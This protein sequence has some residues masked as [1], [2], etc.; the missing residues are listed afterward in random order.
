MGGAQA[1]G[2]KKKKKSLG[3]NVIPVTSYLRFLKQFPTMLLHISN[4]NNNIN[5]AVFKPM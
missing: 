3:L 4:V 1:L 5:L 2:E